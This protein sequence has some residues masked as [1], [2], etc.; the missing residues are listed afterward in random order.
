MSWR[1]SRR[2]TSPTWCAL[3]DEVTAKANGPPSLAARASTIVTSV[4]WYRARLGRSLR[5]VPELSSAATSSSVSG[6]QI[7]VARH[8]D[9]ADLLLGNGFPHV[10]SVQ[11][12]AARDDHPAIGQQG[13]HGV[14]QSGR[15]YEWGDRHCRRLV[16]LGSCGHR[17]LDCFVECRGQSGHA[18]W[19]EDRYHQCVQQVGLPPDHTFGSAGGATRVHHELIRT[20]AR[21]ARTGFGRGEFPLKTRAAASV[22]SAGSSSC[23]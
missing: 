6:W 5:A 12:I 4:C 15:V 22:S 23:V 2:T 3:T 19:P 13:A 16:A 21:L 14:E 1:S 11:P 20:G 7:A 8:D 18:Q 9:H 10:P 17:Q